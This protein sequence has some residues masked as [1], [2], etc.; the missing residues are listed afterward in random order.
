[1]TRLPLSN[2]NNN[3]NNNNNSNTNDFFNN[4]VRTTILQKGE[5]DCWNI[6]AATVPGSSLDSMAKAEARLQQAQRDA[7]AATSDLRTA[8][9]IIAEG[10]YQSIKMKLSVPIYGVS[11][12]GRREGK[13]KGRGRGGRGCKNCTSVYVCI[14]DF[15]L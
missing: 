15:P 2:N 1:M 12:R 14:D 10:L 11:V 7:D 4:R 13:R 9:R 8:I 5:E 6:L 3:N